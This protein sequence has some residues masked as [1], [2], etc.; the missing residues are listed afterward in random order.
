MQL[1]FHGHACVSLALPDGGGT[2]VIDPGSFSDTQAALNGAT[3]VLIT[4]DHADHLDAEAVLQHLASGTDAHVWGPRSAIDDLLSGD[5]PTERVHEVTPGDVLHISG[6]QVT[7]GG[8]DHAEI[9]PDAPRLAR[10]VTYHVTTPGRGIYH[11][12]DSYTAPDA[13]PD[14]VLDVLLVP[15]SGPWVKLAEV[16]D[17]ARAVPAA[18]VV[19]IHDAPLSEVGHT[20][21]ARWLDTARLGGKYTYTRLS[22]GESLTV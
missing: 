4:H 10:N 9:H 15:V 20:L 12:G 1:T 18:V 7:V 3:A 6:A 5:A 13:L 21:T 17:F 14:D 19:P 2:L 8:G 11:P 22:A 16:I